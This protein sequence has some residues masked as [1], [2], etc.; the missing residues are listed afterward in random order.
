MLGVSLDM[1]L[2]LLLHQ[3]FLVSRALLFQGTLELLGFVLHL[4]VLRFPAAY[5]LLH[6]LVQVQQLLVEPCR[7]IPRFA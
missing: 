2:L 5:P 4:L 6:R 7:L 1:L 3:L